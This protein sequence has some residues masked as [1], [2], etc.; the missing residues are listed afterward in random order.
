MDTKNRIAELRR[1][2]EIANL[3][4][5]WLD[6]GILIS[7]DNFLALQE[8]M[9]LQKIILDKLDEIDSQNLCDVYDN[10]RTDIIVKFSAYIKE[11][12]NINK[13]YVFFIKGV[14]KIGGLILDGK[15]VIENQEFILKESE[16]FNQGCSIFFCT[17][18]G[19]SGI[20]LW[21]G[22]YDYRIYVW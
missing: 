1:K 15:T 4:K 17:R 12:I 21:R 3:C 6:N 10:Q 8:T 13:E 16:F 19:E 20:C 14:T 7:I 9:L 18:D 5:V 2:N 11:H 22:E